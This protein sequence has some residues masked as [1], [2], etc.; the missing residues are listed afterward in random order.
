MN[1]HRNRHKG[2]QVVQT[3][4]GWQRP[5]EGVLKVNVDASVFPEENSFTIGIIVRDHTGQF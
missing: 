5:Q 4:V 3:E 1:L 2:K